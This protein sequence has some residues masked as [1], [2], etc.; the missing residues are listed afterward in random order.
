MIGMGSSIFHPEASRIVYLASA[1]KK[2]IAQSIFQLG[3]NS[4]SAL[5]PL[6]AALIIMPYG[7]ANIKW[8]CLAGLIGILVMNS[9]VKWYRKNANTT[10]SNKIVIKD[11]VQVKLSKKRILYS[12]SVLLLLIF[13]KYFYLACI[14]NYY[15]FFLIDKF[16]MSVQQ[17]QIYLFIFL[18]SSAA[19]TLIGGPLGDRFGRKYIIW[20]SILGI[21]PFTLL[22]PYA[23][24]FWTLAFSIIIGVILSSAF[25]AILNFAVDLVPHKLG[26]ISGLFFGFAFGMAGLGSA[27][28]G[29]IADMTSVSFVFEICSFLP[30]IGI[31]TVFLP[32]L[33]QLKMSS[34]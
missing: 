18:G 19:G 30:L 26:L 9:I 17:S 34:K 4:G 25:S 8:F 10:L 14:N 24:L 1:G 23:S 13:S 11:G 21:T 29:K 27:V 22:L 31:F 20:I 5:A 32:D 2:G 33:K 3:G 28:L 15:T 6:L 16:H 12:L 7:Q